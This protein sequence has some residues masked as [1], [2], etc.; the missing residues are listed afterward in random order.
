V[1]QSF[2]TRLQWGPDEP[3]HIIYVQ[4]L[5]LD[6]RLPA[7]THSTAANAYLP[8]AAR[9]HQAQHPPLYYA[10]AAL[11]WRAFEGRP[12]HLVRYTDPTTGDAYA[13]AV[14]GPVR[15]VRFLSI[16]LGALTILFLWAAAQTA[17]PDRPVVWL[18]GTALAA[19]IPMFTYMNSVISNDP[20]L[21]AIFAATAWQWARISRSGTTPRDLILLGLLLGLGL[22]TKET[23][24][25]LLPLSLLLLAEDPAARTWRQRLAG[26]AAIIA[27]TAAL[28]GW[29]FIRKDLLYGSPFVYP[30]HA[31]LLEL[32]P[33]QRA[34]LLR[35]LPARIFLFAFIPIDAIAPHARLD[36]LLAFFG[37]LAALSASGLLVLCLRRKTLGLA[38]HS[39][40]SLLLWLAAGAL[41][42]TGLW[43]NLL[44]VD[45]RMGTSGGRLLLCVLP[46]LALA[47]AR[48]LWALFG[49]GPRGAQASRLHCND[50]GRSGRWA[51]VGLAVVVALLLAVNAYV[52]WGT[53]SEYG[54]LGLSAHRGAVFS[55]NRESFH[56]ISPYM[57]VNREGTGAVMKANNI[58]PIERELNGAVVT[59]IGDANS[60]VGL[61]DRSD[62]DSWPKE[63][64][65]EALLAR[66]DRTATG[67]VRR[68]EVLNSVIRSKKVR[69]HV[70]WT[71][72]SRERRL[73]S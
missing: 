40:L 72:A 46:L 9:T 68:S 18:A 53:A 34:L 12:D 56:C 25:S 52:I 36:L 29:W 64:A 59:L 7:L 71:T 14:P 66:M 32:P 22:N 21:G 50:A 41:V 38:R 58:Q 57:S 24:L 11:V 54:T 39:A 62:S 1:A 10:L 70:A 26:M 67:Y 44:T 19:F 55:A 27:L 13:F 28:G 73:H 45:W 49:G 48:G 2:A 43:W 35:A 65:A 17:F 63:R 31:P 6:G 33:G 69:Q 20:L 47:S 3:A 37:A 16:F 4:S 8:G 51:Q 5:A 30:F 60:G 42:L 23:A 61:M 15:P